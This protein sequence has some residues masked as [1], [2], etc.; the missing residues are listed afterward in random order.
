MVSGVWV[1]IG[2]VAGAAVGGA[3]ALITQLINQRAETRR[4]RDDINEA[5]RAEILTQV[6]SYLKLIEQ[7]E[8]I[9]VEKYDRGKGSE[10][11]DLRAVETKE[12]IW[13]AQRM[14]ELLC[15]QEVSVA[16]H[17]LSSVTDEIIKNGPSHGSV[18]LEIRPKRK[19]FIKKVRSQITHPEH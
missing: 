12:A 7:A 11:L 18:V 1:V 9:A 2:S 3:V 19:E 17:N 13:V 6:I 15:E 16:A 8:L 4:R 14:I 10:S 5:R